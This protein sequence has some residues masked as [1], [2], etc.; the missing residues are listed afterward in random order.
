MS[1]RG[2]W[3][4]RRV[5]EYGRLG[6]IDRRTFV[7][8]G[9][10]GAAALMLGLGPFE[11]RAVAQPRFTGYPFSLGV[12]SGTPTSD[13]G[14]VLWTRLAPEPL[15]G[16]HGGM[17]RE[18]VAVRWELANDENFAQVVRQG[19]VD[20]RY[21]LAHSVH[22][23]LRGLGAGREYYYR[24]KAGGEISPVGRTRTAPA[25]GASP[26]RLA[27]A[28]ASCQMYEHGFYH[29]FRDISE[30]DLDL[31]LH[32]GDYI[33][34]Y[35]PPPD[36]DAYLANSGNVRFHEPDAETSKLGVYRVRHA[37]YKT[38]PDL[39]AAHAAHPWIVTSDDHEVENNY[40]DE[41]SERD[42]NP[43]KFLERRASA[44]KAFYEHMPLPRSSFPQGPDMRLYRRHLYGDLAEFNVL[45]TR[46]YRTDQA[47]DDGLDPP[48]RRTR[49]PRRTM[50]G[51]AQERWLF[52]GLDRFGSTWNVLAQQVFFAQLDFNAAPDMELYNMDAWDGY[53]A[54]RN[55]IVR[56]LDERNVSNPVVLTGDIH[57]NWA[58]DIKLDFD[59]PDS[60]TVGTEYVG[61]SITSTGNGSGTTTF[62]F[63]DNP[64]IKFVNDDR[65]YLLCT[66]TPDL[67]TTDYRVVKAVNN[68]APQPAV[69]LATF[70]TEA[71]NPGAQNTTGPIPVQGTASDIRSLEEDRIEAQRQ[72]DG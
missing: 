51:D 52:D 14:I 37:Q 44:Y 45:D 7:R 15:A 18:K 65:G 4:R 36:P 47:N 26:A 21:E 22:V 72:G 53:E 29:A 5:D 23:E 64:H 39:Q 66:L 59:D 31:V 60:K 6:E 35:P 34:E 33:Y 12:A 49:N 48:N 40:A 43:R 68:P 8:L 56:F 58:N 24:F 19:T 57:I 50:T 70:V 3:D 67:W 61:T 41:I 28:V 46:Q 55:R 10:A 27:F 20:A 32:L 13:G 38:D 69:T 42:S 63:P 11:E 30:Q 54:Q 2:N 1:I 17:P 16:G 9:G 25:A 62:D 71:G